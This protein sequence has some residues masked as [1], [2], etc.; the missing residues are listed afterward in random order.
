MK[1]IA[2]LQLSALVL[3]VV[4]GALPTQSRAAGALAVALPPDVADEGFAFG[5]GYRYKTADEANEGALSRCQKTT[6]DKLRPLCKVILSF[7]HRCVAV[8]MDPKDGTPGVGWAVENTLRAAKAR[9]IQKCR[10]TAGPR[11]KFCKVQV[12]AGC[13]WK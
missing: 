3:L 9:A 4:A 8:A 13:D 11:G 5:T 6:S 10:E 1:A 7:N 2:A 12:G